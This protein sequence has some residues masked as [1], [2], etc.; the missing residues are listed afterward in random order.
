M[1]VHSRKWT[2]K[3]TEIIQLH[4]DLSEVESH[5]NEI[6]LGQENISSKKSALMARVHELYQIELDSKNTIANSG[7]QVAFNREEVEE[8]LEQMNTRLS[9]MGAVNLLALE[10]REELLKENQFYQNQYE[11]LSSSKDKLLEAIT[12][13]DRFC[14]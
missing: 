12:K 7:N 13:I 4:E 6:K 3:Q 9:R 1:S 10:E 8:E 14:F 11:D 5:I 2:K